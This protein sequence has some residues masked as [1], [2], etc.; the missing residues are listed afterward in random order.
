MRS[1][2]P[3]PARPKEG[4][5]RRASLARPAPAALAPGRARRLRSKAPAAMIAGSGTRARSGRARGPEAARQPPACSQPF[6]RSPV[7][8]AEGRLGHRL[9]SKGAGVRR[10]A[11]AEARDSAPGRRWQW[12]LPAEA[13]SA[14]GRP[15]GGFPDTAGP[16]ERGARCPVRRGAGSGA[17]ALEGRRAARSARRRKGR[18]QG[19]GGVEGAPAVPGE[20]RGGQGHGARPPF[21]PWKQLPAS[22]NR[23]AGAARRHCWPWATGA[24]SGLLGNGRAPGSGHWLE[25]QGGRGGFPRRLRS[26]PPP[27]GLQAAGGLARAS[28]APER[29]QTRGQ[30]ART[31]PAARAMRWLTATW[32]WLSLTPCRGPLGARTREKQAP[33]PVHRHSAPSL[34]VWH[35]NQC[36]LTSHL[37]ISVNQSELARCH[38]SIY[39]FYAIGKFKSSSWA[40]LPRNLFPH[41]TRLP[42][43]GTGQPRAQPSEAPGPPCP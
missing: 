19:A 34:G 10:G 41:H 23:G 1:A 7:R 18:A 2:P 43:R 31:P 36:P 32:T 8:A 6:A 12:A 42:R 16:V 20:A 13:G 27:G 17:R 9:V 14:H 25:G 21:S 4:A 30:W 39:T 37:A 22:P 26:P 24:S 15:R 11:A 38:K 40:L 28:G 29:P 33:G 3:G 35:S 5:G